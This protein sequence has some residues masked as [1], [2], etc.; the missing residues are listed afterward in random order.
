MRAFI[1]PKLWGFSPQSIIDEGGGEDDDGG[2]EGVDNDDNDDDDD[3]NDDDDDGNDDDDDDY[4]LAIS[5]KRGGSSVRSSLPL[6]SATGF[7][8]QS[9]SLASF[10]SCMISQIRIVTPTWPCF[11]LWYWPRTQSCDVRASVSHPTMF[12][13][14]TKIL[15]P[16]QPFHLPSW[17][18]AR[19]PSVGRQEQ[20]KGEMRLCNK[21]FNLS[22]FVHYFLMV[23]NW[24]LTFSYCIWNEK[25]EIVLKTAGKRDWSRLIGG[26]F[27][28]GISPTSGQVGPKILVML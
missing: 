6:I 3:D 4:E 15:F 12:F 20:H 2:Y 27:W 28:D 10:V 9:L 23:M 11:R 5:R 21:T 1:D 17:F 19:K 22:C 8:H 25:I 24:W 7:Q 26:W 14:P 13:K 18:E 16:F